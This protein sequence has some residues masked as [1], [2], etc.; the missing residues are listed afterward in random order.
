MTSWPFFTK[1][2]SPPEDGAPRLAESDSKFSMQKAA[3]LPTQKSRFDF[4]GHNLIV[5]SG[6]VQEPQEC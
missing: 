5:S 1:P 4:T 2:N 6:D 3:V